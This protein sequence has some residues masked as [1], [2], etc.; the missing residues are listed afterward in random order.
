MTTISDL[1]AQEFR[2]CTALMAGDEP[3]LAAMLSDDLVHIHLNGKVDD[4]PGYLAGVRGLYTFHAITRGDLTIRQ[5][6]DAAVM[7]GPLIQ[8]IE[9]RA[10]GQMIDVTA[11]TTQVWNR[12]A[13]GWVLNT[14][15]N[16]PVA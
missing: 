9:V 3:T 8:R 1:R 14:C 10:T 13:Q 11:I 12:T 6:G 4:K 2:R 5:F 7:T 16:A 15:H